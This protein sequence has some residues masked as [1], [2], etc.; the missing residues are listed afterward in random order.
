MIFP[1]KTTSQ[2]NPWSQLER[3]LNFDTIIEPP[4]NIGCVKNLVTRSFNSYP[5]R[6]EKI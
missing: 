4:E 6:I 2:P 1:Q 3:L 5:Y